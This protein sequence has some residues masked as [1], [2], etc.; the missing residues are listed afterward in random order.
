MQFEGLQ[1]HR[2]LMRSATLLLA[3]QTQGHPVSLATLVLILKIIIAFDIHTL[4]HRRS[5]SCTLATDFH[6]RYWVICMVDSSMFCGKVMPRWA[7]V[8][9]KR[10]LQV[11]V[12][13]QALSPNKE[14]CSSTWNRILEVRDFMMFCIPSEHS[15]CFSV[16]Q[17]IHVFNMFGESDCRSNYA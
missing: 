8:S 14:Q 7:I 11:I 17:I 12:Y 4:V 5:L 15:G 10:N 3:F 9:Q 1:W 13:L 2:F 6:L 16:A